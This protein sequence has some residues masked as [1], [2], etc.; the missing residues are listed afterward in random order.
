[1]RDRKNLMKTSFQRFFLSEASHGR[2]ITVSY[3]KRKK[4]LDYFVFL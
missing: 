4:G 2:T 1:M 3:K